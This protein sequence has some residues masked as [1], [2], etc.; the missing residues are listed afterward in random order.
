MANTGSNRV[1]NVLVPIT[2]MLVNAILVIKF[3]P[4]S[5]PNRAPHLK[6]LKM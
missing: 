4:T 5:I 1:T 6:F 2:I 3:I